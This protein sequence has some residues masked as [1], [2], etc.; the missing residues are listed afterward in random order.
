MERAW[1]GFEVDGCGHDDRGALP[2]R[3]APDR[4]TEVDL[5]DVTCLH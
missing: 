2:A 5:D 3:L 4:D 1:I